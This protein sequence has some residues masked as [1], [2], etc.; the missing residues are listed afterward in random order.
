M[1]LVLAVRSDAGD[2]EFTAE[3]APL[4]RLS[5]VAPTPAQLRSLSASVPKEVERLAQAEFLR[6]FGLCG[7]L[8]LS[9]KQGDAW[10]FSTHIGYGGAPGP[11]ITILFPARDPEKQTPNQSLQPTAPSGR[12]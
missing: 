1:F 7:M 11:T 4:P 5:L 6:R 10:I 12:G 3:I 2:L 9:E 8:R